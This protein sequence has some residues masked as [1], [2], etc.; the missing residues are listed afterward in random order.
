[1]TEPTDGIRDAEESSSPKQPVA[2]DSISRPIFTSAA[3]PKYRTTQGPSIQTRK[4]PDTR[5]NGFS[6]STA[7]V[8]IP[9]SANVR[10]LTSRSAAGKQIDSSDQQPE[11]AP[12]PKIESFEPDSNAS[13]ERP[14]HSLKQLP[15]TV[16][17]D[18]GIQTN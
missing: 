3:T 16:S 7:T 15:E 4:S 17:T 1:V 13:V 11:T 8:R 6:G 18:E 12:S 10:P 14:A 2:I 5:K 9:H